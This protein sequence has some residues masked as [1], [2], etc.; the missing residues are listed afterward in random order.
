MPAVRDFDQ[1]TVTVANR[2]PDQ[3]T[4]ILVNTG[5]L[6][7]VVIPA[8][9]RAAEAAQQSVAVPVISSS[10]SQG[11]YDGAAFTWS[12]GTLAKGQTAVLT[13]L[14][15]IA[16]PGIFRNRQSRATTRRIRTRRTTRTR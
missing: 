15:E 12:V 1:F 8:S 11:T 7:D 6:A 14:I 4:G 9:A 13:G 3:A 16:Q 2:G 5:F 10:A